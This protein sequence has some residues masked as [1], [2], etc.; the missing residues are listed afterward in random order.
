MVFMG[1]F[2]SLFSVQ[3]I[4]FGTLLLEQIKQ[5]T[6]SPSAASALFTPRQSLLITHLQIFALFLQTRL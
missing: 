6:L 3:S 4:I 1:H 2:L 5:G